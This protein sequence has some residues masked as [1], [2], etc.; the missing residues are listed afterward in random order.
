MASI[1]RAF[2]DRSRTLLTADYLP[3]IRACVGVLSE[4]DVWWRPNGAS[5]SLGHLL[6]HLSGNLRQWV[7]SGLGGSPD[8]RQ[9]H[10]EF[11][12]DGQAGARA[13]VDDLSRTVAEADAVL[14][15][16]DSSILQER[17]VIQ[18]QSV[19]GFE[20]VYTVV[21]HFSMH[22]GQIIYIAKLRS[23]RDLGFYEVTNGIA[24]PRWPG[25]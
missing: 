10:L 23:G 24:R 25:R 15:G 21:E 17:R 9:R 7:V 5:N 16:L 20:A 1:E 14:A 2:V 19:T 6:L 22:T 3:K 18:G 4:D 12:P 8:R 11:D 13:L